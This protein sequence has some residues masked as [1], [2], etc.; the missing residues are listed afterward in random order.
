MNIRK[1]LMTSGAAVVALII[2]G[3][4]WLLAAFIMIF[5]S[6][7]LRWLFVTIGFAENGIILL[8]KENFIDWLIPLFLWAVGGAVAM[9]LSTR[10]FRSANAKFVAYFLSF[11]AVANFIFALVVQP[12]PIP[13]IGGVWLWIAQTLGV[14]LGASSI[15]RSTAR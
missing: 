6:A 7:L 15:Y 3:L 10:I 4:Y 8:I 9:W 1:S 12:L 11:F 14:I 5:I 2:L 13:E